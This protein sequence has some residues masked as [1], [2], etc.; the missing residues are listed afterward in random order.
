MLATTTETWNC[1]NVKFSV[2]RS[3]SDSVFYVTVANADIGSLKHHLQF[4]NK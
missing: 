3:G 4:L 1:L 2:T